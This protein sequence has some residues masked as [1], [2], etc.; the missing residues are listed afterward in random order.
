MP[1][2]G[3]IDD[4]AFRIASSP[5]TERSRGSILDTLRVLLEIPELEVEDLEYAVRRHLAEHANLAVAIAAILDVEAVV[6]LANEIAFDPGFCSIGASR[7]TAISKLLEALGVRQ[8]VWD[9]RF[10]GIH[11]IRQRLDELH[12][13]VMQSRRARRISSA[14]LQRF[15]QVGWA[16]VETLLKVA[17]RFYA[18]LFGTGA[19]SSV[20]RCFRHALRCRTLGSIVDAIMD[21]E[22]SFEEQPLSAQQC[23]QRLGRCSPFGGMFGGM[24]SVD[25]DDVSDDWLRVYRRLAGR[26]GLR[27]QEGQP[28]YL[29]R[30]FKVKTDIRVYRNFFAH[31]DEPAVER[32][33][34]QHALRSLRAARHLV[35]TLNESRE[36]MIYPRLVVPVW[37]GQDAFGRTVVRFVSELDLRDDGS[38]DISR[39]CRMYPDPATRRSLRMH[40]F[41]FC[42]PVYDGV[43]DPVVCSLAGVRPATEVE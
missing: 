30:F 24:V 39:A 7:D 15:G 21:I 28:F 5:H 4:L 26:R 32:L 8:V 2:P 34:W 10:R 18:Q 23:R 25:E 19:D 12:E 27:R 33:G 13:E 11:R 1:Q 37:R 17:V 22:E 40:E 16:Y 29:E 6:Y 35:V 38:Y 9:P 14:E 31:K 42:N 36:G 43:F 20:G 3:P 41:Y